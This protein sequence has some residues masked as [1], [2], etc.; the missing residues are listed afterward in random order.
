MYTS[1]TLQHSDYS[2]VLLL[3]MT[4]FRVAFITPV[5]RQIYTYTLAAGLEA[6]RLTLS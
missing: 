3:L 6:E 2:A 5:E 4:V 1:V